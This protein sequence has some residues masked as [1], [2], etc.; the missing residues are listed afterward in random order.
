M[1]T[2]V[3]EDPAAAK[4]F[5]RR[6]NI[7]TI[8]LYIVVGGIFAA[9]ILVLGEEFVRHIDSLEAWI[10]DLGPW[11]LVAFILLYAVL[12]TL[13]VPD[14]VLGIIAGTTFGFS[15][16][17][18]AALLG[19][20]VGA[21]LQYALAHRLLRP[22]V[23]KIVAAK[24]TLAAIQNAVLQQ[25]F[26]LQLLIRL[27]PLN[28]TLTNYMLGA[29][30]VGFARFVAACVGFLPTVCLEVYVG[31]AGKQMVGMATQP[32]NNVVLQDA[33]LI[34]GLLAAIIVTALISRL[35][36]RAVEEVTGSP[37][38]AESPIRTAAS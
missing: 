10:A 11:A 19:S 23:E 4:R 6:E 28:R 33:L 26:R 7:A 3:N 22:T 35:A 34:L 13:F 27:T 9:G 14:T 24:P 38:G 12:G 31:Y 30:G 36:R 20:L 16:G 1:N 18:L 15:Q 21:V 37:P 2:G 29:S 25:E 17:L 32:G 8:A 5:W